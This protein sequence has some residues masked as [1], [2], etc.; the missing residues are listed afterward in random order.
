MTFFAAFFFVAVAASAQRTDVRGGM[1]Y[2]DGKPYALLDRNGCGAI[3]SRCTVRISSPDGRTAILI[4]F[5]PAS[6]GGYTYA[7]M[8]FIKSGQKARVE[9][10]SSKDGKVAKLIVNAKLFVNGELDDAAA[11]A[12]VKAH[13]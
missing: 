10:L 2:A 12:F 11:A 13:P 3:S 1:V 6:Y 7:T 4:N 9:N 8:E 5:D